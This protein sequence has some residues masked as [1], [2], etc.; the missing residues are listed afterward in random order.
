MKSLARAFSIAALLFTTQALA[1]GAP[2]Q[3]RGKSIVLSWSETRQQ[4]NEGW[5]DFRTVGASRD[6][7][8]YISTAGRVFSKQTNHTRAGSGSTEQVAGEGGNGPY[9]TRVPSFSGQS[10]TIIS[11]TH[12]GAGRLIVDFD[13]SFSTCSAKPSLAFEAGKTSRSFSPITHKWV[14]IKSVTM[15]GTSCSIQNGNVLGGPV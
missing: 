1:A 8:I 6:V 2:A 11:E 15:S 3:L 4:K 5:T 13:A 7:S 12:G 10:M 9:A 14:E